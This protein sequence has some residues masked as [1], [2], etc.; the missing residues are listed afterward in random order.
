MTQAATPST[1]PPYVTFE[2]FVT[3]PSI[4][5]CSEWVEGRVVPMS[6]VTNEHDELGGWLI[7]LIST[8]NEIRQ[9]GRLHYEPFQMKVPGQDISRAPDI[10]FVLREHL[11][12]IKGTYLEG[13]ADL[14]I[15]II[16]PGSVRVD[17]GEKF[18]EY[19]RAGVREYWL[20]DPHRRTDDFYRLNA[21]GLYEKLPVDDGVFRSRVLDG[22]WIEVDW[23]WQNPKPGLFDIV[24]RWGIR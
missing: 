7:L 6:P 17:R 20:L 13:P 5:E 10:M 3:D 22:F 19:E 15:E 9:V 21:E 12:R 2:R 23:L 11:G 16:S 8:F 24:D 18:D 4:P 1:D 14:V